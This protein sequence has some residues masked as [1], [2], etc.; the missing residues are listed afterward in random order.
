MTGG[1]SATGI[2]ARSVGGGGGNGGFSIGAGVSQAK[3]ANSSVGGTGGLGG[4][5]LD[6]TVT[7]KSTGL[8]FTNGA[9]AYGIQAQSIGGGGIGR[10][11]V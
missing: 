5:G 8:I 6:V 4:V 3:S 11:H 7:N 9:M 10:A 2:V 1:A